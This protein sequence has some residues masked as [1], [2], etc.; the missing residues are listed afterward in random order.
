MAR[1][2]RPPVSELTCP[3]VHLCAHPSLGVAFDARGCC[4]DC[5]TQVGCPAGT[6]QPAAR[7]PWVRWPNRSR[8]T[9][10]DLA[11]DFRH[12]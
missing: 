9:T 7:A 2:L 8:D 10:P 1:D 11:E 4:V 3:R 12:G 6:P 5:G